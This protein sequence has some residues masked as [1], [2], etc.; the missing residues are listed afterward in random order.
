MSLRRRWTSSSV[1]AAGVAVLV[2]VGTSGALRALSRAEAF[3]HSE[4][5]GL[6]PTCLGCHAGIPGGDEERYYTVVVVDC[7]RCHDGERVEEVEWRDPVR[8]ATNLVFSHPEHDREVDVAGDSALVCSDCHALPDF[9]RRMDVG[10]AAPENCISCHTHASD[11]HVSPAVECA[12]CH[13]SL[14]A[15]AAIPASR[16]EAFPSPASH[17][18][19]DFLASHGDAA[20]DVI[21]GASCTVCHTRDSCSRCHLNSSDIATIAGLDQDARVAGL[22]AGLGGEWPEPESHDTQRWAL[23]HGAEAGT[24]VATCANCHATPS[25]ETCHGTAVRGP[26]AGIPEP[27]TDGRTGVEL[28]TLRPPGHSLNFATEHGSAAAADL[29]TCSV[30]HTQDQCGECHEGPRRGPAEWALSSSVGEA[31]GGEPAAVTAERLVTGQRGDPRPRGAG[32][33]PENFVLRHGAE[34]FSAQAVCSDCHSPQAFCRD[35]HDGVGLSVGIRGG[36]GGAYHDAQPNW[37]LGH[38]Q[39]ARMGLE[40]CASCHQETSCLRCHSAKAGLRINPH[41]PSFDPGR[42]ADRSVQSCATCHQAS[43]VLGN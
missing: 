22:L 31:K 3:P 27:A 13:M 26:L 25:C 42:V 16:I 38:G 23:E 11:E 32:Y 2:I 1:V 33:H 34:A 43:D 39:A 24:S 35:C 10:P 7:Q 29:P 37:F 28:P 40:G 4:H 5:A 41:G 36:A 18:R 6:F 14:A 9:T 15:S 30:C 21:E 19:D 8:R 17:E 20:E 12:T